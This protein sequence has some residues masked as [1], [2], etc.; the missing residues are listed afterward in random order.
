MFDFDAEAVRAEVADGRDAV[1]QAVEGV[2]LTGQLAALVS[3]SV[4]DTYVLQSEILGVRDRLA[5]AAV[6]PV[7]VEVKRFACC[8]ALNTV[9]YFWLGLV[10]TA[11]AGLLLCAL[12]LPVIHSLD[13][14]A[15]AS[16]WGRAG[17]DHLSRL[18][19]PAVGYPVG[20][21]AWAAFEQAG[22]GSVARRKSKQPEEAPT[23]TRRADTIPAWYDEKKGGWVGSVYT[24]VDLVCVVLYVF[25]HPAHLTHSTIKLL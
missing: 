9:S 3:A 18:A 14:L 21:G 23:P 4:N 22:L 25:S 2:S 1:L 24:C 19:A 7:Y 20:P 17:R 16:W 11:G 10:L 5:F 6:H 13:R 15:L 12:C 8:T